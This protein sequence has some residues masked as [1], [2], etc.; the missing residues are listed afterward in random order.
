MA[1]ASVGTNGAYLSLWSPIWLR[2]IA[3][4]DQVEQEWALFAMMGATMAGMLTVGSLS[5]RIIRRGG[6]GMI[7][8][9][10]GVALSLTAQVLALLE[11]VSLSWLIWPL[12]AFGS[13]S[14]VGL[15]PL[16]ARRFEPGL[17]GRVNTSLNCLMFAGSFAAQWGVGL[18]INQFPLAANGGYSHAAHQTALAV[19]LAIQ[20]GG[21]LW[22]FL[23]RAKMDPPQGKIA[24]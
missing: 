21:L 24:P 16:L 20:L 7:V 14:M 6:S 19:M 10:G 12:F 5:Q 1:M 3:G 13:A 17:A 22:Y 2:D 15:F 8:I 9:F 11:I 4:F 23:R 18:I